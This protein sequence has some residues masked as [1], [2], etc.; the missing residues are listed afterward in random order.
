MLYAITLGGISQHMSVPE[1]FVP[2]ETYGYSER[3]H[4]Q[5]YM[6]SLP[7]VKDKVVLDAACG[8]GYG[9]Y[10]I[11]Q[12]AKKVVGLD[13]SSESIALASE[14]YNLD[15]L[16]FI[17][18]DIAQLPYSDGCFDIVVSFETIEHVAEGIQT[19]FL[20]EIRRVLKSNGV[21][22]IS[23]P[24]KK[25]TDEC[26]IENKYHIREFY[27]DEF[28]EFIGSEFSNVEF[29]SQYYG[30]ALILHKHDEVNVPIE[31]D[32][33]KNS[34]I[35]ERYMIAVASQ[36]ELPKIKS[37][38]MLLS[39]EDLHMELGSVNAQL[40]QRLNLQQV[41]SQV[42]DAKFYFDTGNGFNE[43]ETT[44]I[45]F[46]GGYFI[47]EINVPQNT[48]RLRFDP[49]EGYSCVTKYFRVTTS[50][51]N[52][53]YQYFNGF[54]VG[55]YHMFL[56][57]DS[58]YSIDLPVSTFWVTV[59]ILVYPCTDSYISGLFSSIKDFVEECERR[60]IQIEELAREKE[61]IRQIFT[62]N[63]NEYETE[64]F[65]ET[66]V[67]KEQAIQIEDLQK[68]I[69]RFTHKQTEKDQR[70]ESLS[71]ELDFTNQEL[72]SSSEK[73]D[74][75]NQELESLSEKLNF[76]NHELVSL[77]EELDFTN[78]ELDILQSENSSQIDEIKELN[79]QLGVAV[80]QAQH[81]LSDYNNIINSRIWKLTK[82]YRLVGQG[83]KNIAYKIVPLRLLVK[84]IKRTRQFGLRVAFK[85]VKAYRAR[86]KPIESG[87]TASYSP[88]IASGTN[89]YDS[90]YQVNYDFSEF[91]TDIKV[92]AFYLPQFHRIPE[93]DAWWG[94]GF[95]EW[96]NTSK[97][98]PAFK[99]HYQPR[100]PHE[101]LDYYRLDTMETFVKTMEKQA[102]IAKQ[103]GI[104]GFCFYYYWFSGKRLLEKPIDMLLKKPEI[105]IKFCLCWANE[106]W[107]RTWDG[108]NR[109][110]LMEQDYS[111]NDPSDFV[112]DI[113]PYLEDSR[114]IRIEGKPVIVVYNPSTIP[115]RMKV[116]D[117]W[118]KVAK[119]LGIGEIFIWICETAGNSVTS[120]KLTAHVD[121]GIE[122]PPH[123][124]G[125]VATFMHVLPLD[126]GH[127][128]DYTSIAL[129]KTS[130]M[131]SS[132]LDEN[133]YP[134]Y[135]TPMMAWDNAARRKEGFK[136]FY[137]YS[138]RSFYDWCC[139]VV[140]YTNRNFSSERRFMFINAWNE[141][142][143]G[144]YLEPDMKYGY[145]NI[146]TLSKALYQLPFNGGYFANDKTEHLHFE[147][148]I[149][150][151]V[152][153]FYLEL[154]D[155]IIENLNAIPYKFDCFIST[156]TQAKKDEIE[157]KFVGA[158][159]ATNIQIAVYPNRGRDVAPFL[160]QMKDVIDNYEYICHIHTKK[161]L[162]EGFGD[163]WRE[164]LYEGL[165]GTEEN[166]KLIFNIFAHDMSVGMLFPQTYHELLV[167][168]TWGTL[169]SWGSDANKSK[170]DIKR[171]LRK[172]NAD[173][174]LPDEPIFPA[175][176]MFW[177]RS[178]AIH[179]TF[180]LALD[181]TDFPE[182]KGQRDETFAHVVE[183]HWA[184]L[185]MSKGFRSA[186]IPASPEN[187]DEELEQGDAFFDI[188]RNKTDEEFL[189]LLCKAEHM[190]EIDGVSLPL[191]PNKELQQQFVGCSGGEAL[192][193]E[194]WKFYKHVKRYA[195]KYKI[196]ID[197]DTKIL[198][199][200]C[201]W[202]R[203]IRY[204]FKDIR[205]ENI[206]G[207]DIDPGLIKICKETLP[208][209][210]Y[211][212]C[213]YRPPFNFTDNSLDIIIALSVFSHLCEE[214]ATQWI[215]EFA[216]VLKPGGI[217]IATTW[218]SGFLDYCKN[219]R[220]DPSQRTSL[221]HETILNAFEPIDESKRRYMAGEFL[222]APT[223]GGGVRESLFYGEALIPEAYISRKW[224]KV[225][226]LKN[227]DYEGS[228]EAV[229]VLQK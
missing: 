136:A 103:H 109:H 181:C 165:L 203:S 20:K 24:N 213:S 112:K 61:S 76:A 158:C 139:S 31:L 191:L 33:T 186:F 65:A 223:G 138:L 170:A 192:R 212:T 141:W 59:E 64:L 91:D 95:T 201:G 150:V 226:I 187:M 13:I 48:V 179:D 67:L 221:W 178:S 53:G 225:L 198:D 25:S 128:F 217:V 228:G 164:Y 83:A 18:G 17:E 215:E 195:K 153:L 131:E 162:T 151:Q 202:G 22:V 78:H 176:N 100:E 11:A 19:A 38:P 156:D 146:N 168:H 188:V 160:Q 167:V 68:E 45:Q 229:F 62:A 50:E 207:V 110:V 117:E 23:T 106:N 86:N 130:E 41:T 52:V 4:R 28:A 7:L 90:E 197:E 157:N 47:H 29:Y 119:E 115:N 105:D 171:F 10:M 166:V 122:F 77:S 56:S 120:L 154:M 32:R 87:E 218:G 111:K 101:D 214:V 2:D 169:Y 89:F 16:S 49:V 46:S 26:N 205:S 135:R 107:T 125:E 149:A 97:A 200:G 140:E 177:A 37:A 199:F 82:P 216:R 36:I 152:H 92:L 69:E 113:K 174:D 98:Q 9:S 185:A 147:T 142:A 161:S 6:F 190:S 143:E 30:D 84:F 172:L 193:G 180:A 208:S 60:L 129:I 85:Y 42:Y 12:T 133:H 55:D 102:A 148:K 93:N 74:F 58:Q 8:E 184:Y 94:E 73:L 127:V 66:E 196:H 3:E 123:G 1:R 210:K 80:T 99:G 39:D 114:Y 182:E 15:N 71:R 134:V 81:H 57:K 54:I 163:D 14:K 79:G 43:N 144:T 194:S 34:I 108:Q 63:I 35:N 96:S 121:G 51:G 137:K 222:Y 40:Q 21:L 206:V 204:F 227:Y 88:H 116:F 220:D 72:M 155:E 211:F 44:V 132:V 224:D 118:R 5:R 209:G 75:A 145:A 175:G 126:V 27:K 159:G 183:R 173:V 219:L 124:C 189:E 70:I 104:H